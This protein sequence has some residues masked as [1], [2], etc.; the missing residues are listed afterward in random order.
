MFSLNWSVI[1]YVVFIDFLA[2]MSPGPD[3]FMVL[4]NSLT[5]S[6]KA[7][8][9]TTLGI[10]LGC[11]ILFLLGV[12]GVGA[13]IAQNKI[14]FTILKFAGALYLIY[15]AIKSL[16]NKSEVSEPQ[17]VYDENSKASVWEYFKIGLVCNLT[18]P[19]AMMFIITL[20]AYITE[21]GNPY[22]D[23]IVI[24]IITCINTLIWFSLV[25]I[26]FGSIKV[27]K[28]FY[29]YQRV[30]NIVFAIVLFYMASKI[31]FL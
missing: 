31:I 30:I 28:V 15:L 17:L 1:V 3:F 16:I 9:Y 26:V 27:R 23:G 8:I 20:A 5:K 10:S 29:R 19:K 14:L 21:K 18:N 22:T 6:H 11:F 25:S 24:S 7:G 13:L 2:I 4:K 12:L